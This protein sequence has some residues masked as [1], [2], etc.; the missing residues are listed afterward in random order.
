MRS[1]DDDEVWGLSDGRW[2]DRD[3]D[4]DLDR[5]R[6]IV[7]TRWTPG[8]AAPRD[9]LRISTRLED[10]RSMFRPRS[11]SASSSLPPPLRYPRYSASLCSRIL[12]WLAC[13]CLAAL[14][15]LSLSTEPLLVIGR[16]P[17]VP[18]CATIRAC[19]TLAS[20][21]VSMNSGNK[22]RSR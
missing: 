11:P 18:N 16:H 17:G 14:S 13:L 21:A 9:V 20:V 5:D 22:D 6:T 15:S 8:D 12:S 1:W 2:R 7:V 19:L 4:L 10:R 3:L